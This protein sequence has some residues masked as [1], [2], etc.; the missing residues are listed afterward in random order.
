MSRNARFR[1]ALEPVLLTRQWDLD[2][3]RMELNRVNNDLSMRNEELAL[4]LGDIETTANEWREQS[5]GAQR[6]GIDKF[7]VVTHY[8][9]DLARQRLAKENLISELEEE[10]DLLMERVAASQRGVEAV[11]DHRDKMKTAF[12]QLR[13]SGDF[14]IADDQ[15]ST[16][17]VRA[18][19]HN[20]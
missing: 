18:G 12:V 7:I 11:E 20:E 17:Q 1:Y 4:V 16:L 3:L 19:M 5:R 14:K 6:L 13:A 9:S 15:W 2:S 8:M 10:R